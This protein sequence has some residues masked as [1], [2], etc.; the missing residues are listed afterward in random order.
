MYNCFNPKP[1][2]TSS[3][4][5]TNAKYAQE[6]ALVLHK[7]ATMT[8]QLSLN[9]A[10]GTPAYPALSRTAYFENFLAV[11]ETALGMGGKAVLR[12]VRV[13]DIGLSTGLPAFNVLNLP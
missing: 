3:T 7:L 1:L 10:P 8:S 11:I 5:F 6:F 13:M 9:G 2:V 4:H 12:V